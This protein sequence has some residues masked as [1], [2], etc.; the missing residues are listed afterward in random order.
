MKNLAPVEN[1]RFLIFQAK[2][3]QIGLVGEAARAVQLA[4]P[5]RHRC[6]VGDQPEALFALLE[7]FLRQRSF[8]DVHMGADQPKRFACFVTLDLRFGG[9]PSHLPIAGPDD[10]VFGRISCI[11]A[12]H[13]R[14][15]MIECPLAVVG[16]NSLDPAVVRIDH[17][18][19]QAVDLLIGEGALSA[20]E[21]VPEV[22]GDPSDPGYSLHAGEI[23]L[24][25]LQGSFG[26]HALRGF[27]HDG[28][29]ARR[30][31]CLVQDRGI[32]Q[33]HPDLLRAV[34]PEQREFLIPVGENASAEADLHHMV[35][36]IG[37]FGPPLT[38]LRPEK[39]RMPAAGKNRISI[40]VDHDAIFA[41]QKHDGHRRPQQGISDGFQTLRPRRKRPEARF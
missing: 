10:P 12:V 41:P 28:D 4:D 3:I 36:E 6:A 32:I 17:V 14:Q 25:I 9:D 15:K 31:T 5:H 38:H 24:A 34:M 29:H 19:A 33:I 40:I 23:I 2:E 11:G 7:Q 22:D 13:G 16:M 37:D 8:G 18:R 1:D 21:V 27:N 39:L 26:D 30:L 20:A 35:V